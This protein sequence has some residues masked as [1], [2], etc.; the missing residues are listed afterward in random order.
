MLN[1]S[2]AAGSLALAMHA[3]SGLKTMTVPIPGS[4]QVLLRDVA[5]QLG[6]T[7]DSGALELLS[8]VDVFLTGRTYNQVDETHTYGQGYN[9]QSPSDL[10]SAGERAWLPQL[11]ENAL[12]R[13]NI[14]ITNTGSATASVTVRLYDSSGNQ[15]GL[16][17]TRSYASGEFYQYQQPYL[18]LGGIASGFAKITVNTGS[19]V[20]AYASVVDVNTGDPTTIT[21][22]R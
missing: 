14:G 16:S 12:Y 10:L 13:T 15:V 20:V 2:S 6:V 17:S 8:N 1:R 21:M 22:K 11:T 3:P 9:G 4:G 19:G 5:G 18:A 7:T